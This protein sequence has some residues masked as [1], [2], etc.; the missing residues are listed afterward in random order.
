MIRC[1]VFPGVELG[2]IIWSTSI[3]THT[4]GGGVRFS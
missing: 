4:L 3:S 2:V 1:S